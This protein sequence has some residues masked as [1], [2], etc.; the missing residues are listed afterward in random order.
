MLSQILTWKTRIRARLDRE[1]F[2]PTALGIFTTSVYII[3]RGL[4]QA[5]K[6][7]APQI[8]GDVLDFGCGSKPYESLFTAARRYVGVDVEVSGHPHADSK[9][10]VYYDG[11]R[12][13]FD[14]A[15]F[16]AVVSFEVIEHVFN[17]DEALGEIHRVLKPGGM[18]LVT[19]PFAWD[20][21]EAPYDF[22][23]YTSF[24][25]RHVLDNAGFDVVE[26]RKTTTSVLAIGQMFIAYM[27]FYVAPRPR[28]LKWFF[29]WLVTTPLTVIV[30]GLNA[31]LPKRQ[32][33]FSNT[34]T[35]ARKRA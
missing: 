11:K 29:Q 5:V 19:A 17:L 14:D 1:Q 22:A 8:T 27:A 25:L 18:L 26:M 16:D 10:D 7:F 32:E 28:I 35:L 21:H 30:L 34:A 13:P 23:R 2:H 9:V 4:F 31:V 33:T 3:R 24:G 12:L 15:E 20:E 6:A